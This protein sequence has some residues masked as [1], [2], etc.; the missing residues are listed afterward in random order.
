MALS[1]VPVPAHGRSVRCFSIS[2]QQRAYITSNS[3]EHRG[4]WSVAL[5]SWGCH[6]REHSGL[7]RKV[8]QGPNN[9]VLG[10]EVFLANCLIFVPL[11]ILIYEYI[12]TMEREIKLYWP[13]R[14]RVGWVSS[15]FLVNRYLSLL[16]HIP[17]L[18]SMLGH[19]SSSYC[20]FLVSYH[21]FYEIV[22]QLLVGALCTIRVYALYQKS[23]HILAFL[24][25]IIFAGIGI[26]IWSILTA[27][28]SGVLIVS[29]APLLVGC[30]QL[31]PRTNAQ[32]LA[33]AW[34]GVLVFDIVIFGLTVYR[35]LRIGRGRLT[36]ILFRDGS[37]Y[38]VALFC[39]NLGNILTLLLASEALSA[40]AT[41]FTNVVSA[42]LI[43]RIML[44]L[45]AVRSFGGTST[46]QATSDYPYSNDT[47]NDTD[48]PALSTLV[49]GPGSTHCYHQSRASYQQTRHS[50]LAYDE[51]HGI[52]LVSYQGLGN[53]REGL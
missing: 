2:G 23:R 1:G 35:T 33:T 16:G 30:T 5:R 46:Q 51:E 42:S 21:S 31:V 19:R 47:P 40:C 27:S 20:T 6:L 39:V 52:E 48:A 15:V 45:R 22:L 43:T 10:C 9:S 26:A 44:N 4:T 49:L 50:H 32:H 53:I 3:D 17:I 38:F 14:H 24:L 36:T 37:L 28:G 7:S 8:M 13:P 11:T 25:L 18:Y 12:V 34:S 29:T 41:T